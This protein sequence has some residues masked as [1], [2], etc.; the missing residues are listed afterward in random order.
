MCNFKTTMANFAVHFKS[1]LLVSF[2]LYSFPAEAEVLDS[3]LKELDAAIDSHAVYV[4]R[5]E[6]RI[7]QLKRMKKTC[8][9]VPESLI[10]LNTHLY[11]EYKAYICDSALHYLNQNIDLAESVRNDFY[12]DQNLLRLSLLLS[13]LGM[14]TEAVDVLSSVN[15]CKM[16][17]DLLPEYYQC[18]N[19]TIVR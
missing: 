17:D 15:R 5:R 13:S 1:W 4:D 19:S 12:K 3:L 2:L 10:K 16:S 14:Y 6:A 9:N 7:S 8:E 18:F 11:F